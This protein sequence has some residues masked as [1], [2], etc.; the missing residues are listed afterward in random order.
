MITVSQGHDKNTALW[1]Y[2]RVASHNMGEKKD[3]E[4][5]MLWPTCQ[6]LEKK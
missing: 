4:R 5:A 2:T 1:G 3:T 6:R